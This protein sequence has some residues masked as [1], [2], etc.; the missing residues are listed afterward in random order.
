M[1][2]EELNYEELP[3]IVWKELSELEFEFEMNDMN[4]QI[5]NELLKNDDTNKLYSQKITK[6]LLLRESKHEKNYTP[7]YCKEIIPISSTPSKKKNAKQIEVNLFSIFA[8]LFSILKFPHICFHSNLR[9]PFNN[10]KPLFLYSYEKWKEDSISSCI[11][12]KK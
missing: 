1:K 4:C 11:K 6:V 9:L 12:K 7:S 8:G 2:G 5:F 10:N 3:S